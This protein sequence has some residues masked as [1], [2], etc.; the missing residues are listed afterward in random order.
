MLYDT[1]S[2]RSKENMSILTLLCSDAVTRDNPLPCG[3][4]GC[5][6]GRERPQATGDAG[7]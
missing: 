6:G 3:S 7:Q 4:K 5:G 2:S 1:R